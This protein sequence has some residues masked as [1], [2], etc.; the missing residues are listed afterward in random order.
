MT[1]ASALDVVGQIRGS[2]QVAF[3]NDADFSGYYERI[4]DF[5]HTITDFTSSSAWGWQPFRSIIS[6]DPT[7]DLTGATGRW[8]YGH[9]L[10]AG[11]KSG[12][13]YDVEYVA[14][15]YNLASHQGTGKVNNLLGALGAAWATGD[16][17]F[18]GG[19]TGIAQAADDAIVDYNVGVD[20]ITGHTGSTGSVMNNYGIRIN[21]PWTTSP[22][23]ENFG[24]YIHDQNV[25]TNNSYAIYSN[26]G[27]SYFAGNVGIGTDQ[28]TAALHVDGD[29]VATGT[30]NFVQN[31][32]EDPS[33]EIHFV[34]LEGNE[35]GTYF[36][37]TSTLVDGKAVIPVP[38]EFSMVSESEGLTVQVTAMGPGAGLWVESVDLNQIVVRGEKDVKFSYFANGVRA[39]YADFQSLRSK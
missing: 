2:D 9:E 39:G 19:L 17:L 32:P 7:L 6:V 22:L 34:C 4:F 29:F 1:P 37:G 26:G 13:P 38:E 33:K 28:P 23:M 15:T 16:V 25:G 18:A 11:V 3:G 35:A 27:D 30:K 5:S 21:T 8:I 10:E 14:G 24:L 36:R 20:V 31:H 12:N